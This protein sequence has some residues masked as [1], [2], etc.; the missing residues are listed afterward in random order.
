MK[1]LL[2]RLMLVSFLV[3]YDSNCFLFNFGLIMVNISMNNSANCEML[4]A[5]LQ[6]A[7]MHNDWKIGKTE[8]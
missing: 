2:K 8:K 1:M 7:E 6:M 5:Y 3:D 4:R